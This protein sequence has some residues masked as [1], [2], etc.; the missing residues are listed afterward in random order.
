MSFNYV[1]YLHVFK[2]YARYCIKEGEATFKMG[3]QPY[4]YFMASGEA[5]REDARKNGVKG[6]QK[7]MAILMDTLY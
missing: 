4:R 3:F 7:T 6:Q 5:D 2:N 1:Y